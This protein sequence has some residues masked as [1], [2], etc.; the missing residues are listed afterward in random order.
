MYCHVLRASMVASYAG[1]AQAACKRLVLVLMHHVVVDWLSICRVHCRRFSR[2]ALCWHLCCV[3]DRC[4]AMLRPV[5]KPALC[6]SGSPMLA[7]ATGWTW[8]LS[9]CGLCGQ[10]QF[11]LLGPDGQI[12]ISRPGYW[13]EASDVLQQAHASDSDSTPVSSAHSCI[14][15]CNT[16]AQILMNYLTASYLS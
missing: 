8:L 15:Y 13:C 16:A 7:P 9:V 1:R 10:P 11:W 4:S 2:G 12:N 14:Q 6:A 5:H 3:L